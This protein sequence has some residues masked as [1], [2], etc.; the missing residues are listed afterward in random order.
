MKILFFT[1]GGK[2]IASSRQ[3]VW[4]LA[5]KLKVNYGVQ[6]DV[7]YSISYNLFSI[8]VYRFKILVTVLRSL[9]NKEY[10]LFF[11]HKS[12]FPLDVVVCII[13][14]SKI[15]RVPIIYDLDDAEW[16]HSGLKTWLLTKKSEI[17]FCGSHFIYDKIGKYTN[18]AILIPTVIDFD[19]YEKYT[20]HH[21]EKEILNLGWVGAGPSYFRDKHLN[22][23]EEALEKLS[24]QIG[25]RVSLTFI[26][27]GGDVLIKKY[28]TNKGFPVNFIDELNWSNPN[29]VPRSLKENKVD[30]GVAPML[31]T[32][33]D[34]AK[35]AFKVIEY[36][37]VG[38]PVIV[39]PIGEQI[40]VCRDGVDGFYAENLNEWVS[41]IM[42]LKDVVLRKKIGE[43]AQ[44]RV[45]KKY[46][47]QAILSEVYH[48]IE[49]FRRL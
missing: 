29:E 42:K 25:L 28:F 30:I 11:V 47:Y 14:A 40:I 20:L 13:L 35:C 5:E 15:R 16:V 33:F 24:K 37:A 22:I 10:D 31:E 2:D 19:I 27:S 7:I 18:K 44:K 48:R 34:K 38:I 26:G 23:L 12:H 43:S 6:H 46:S 4:Q 1:K 41:S 9:F 36:M 21:K 32:K 39:S 17:V 49:G 45:K 8:S 3:R